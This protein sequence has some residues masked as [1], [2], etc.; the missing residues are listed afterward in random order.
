MEHQ[1]EVGGCIHRPA[2]RVSNHAGTC[3]N[4]PPRIPR[5]TF[6]K[7]P[8]VS[9]AQHCG[10][11]V[12]MHG[13]MQLPCAQGGHL[14]RHGLSRSKHTTIKTRPD[15]PRLRNREIRALPVRSRP[16]ALARSAAWC[17]ELSPRPTPLRRPRTSASSKPAYAMPD[18]PP[19][20]AAA[21]A[22]KR[23][24]RMP[25]ADPLPGCVEVSL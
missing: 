25:L 5:S 6:C 11:R 12:H 8:K 19:R 17:A 21:V 16:T 14:F 7:E 4:I 22:V 3:I 2:R 23:M 10:K 1:E 18:V 20:H 13:V 15:Q 9:E 24:R